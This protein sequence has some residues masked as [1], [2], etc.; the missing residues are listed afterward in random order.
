MI[1]CR[2]LLSMVAIIL[3]GNQFNNIAAND[4]VG[5]LFSDE[6]CDQLE[7]CLDDNA[8]G[9]CERV[10][11]LTAG[12]TLATYQHSLNDKTL[13]LL[14]TEMQRL[15]E[16]GNR[17]DNDYTQCV[18][19]QI[20][21][22]HRL[23]IDY[24]PG[25]C[26]RLLHLTAQSTGPK[27]IDTNRK[28]PYSTQS[29]IEY[30]PDYESDFA[31]ELFLRLDDNNK[32][33]SN[34]KTGDNRY[35]FDYK[36]MKRMDNK[37]KIDDK[38]F[39]FI[40]KL[41]KEKL[42]DNGIDDDIIGYD[43]PKH[44]IAVVDET[45]LSFDNN[46]NDN[47][48]S[49]FYDKSGN[50]IEWLPI[51]TDD[52]DVVNDDDVDDDDQ[53]IIG[54][55]DTGAH[56][57]GR[58]AAAPAVVSPELLEKSILKSVSQL[59]GG[60]IDSM[61]LLLNRPLYFKP[62]I[63]TGSRDDTPDEDNSNVDE[64]NGNNN[65][66]N[67][68]R[69]LIDGRQQQQDYGNNYNELLDN[70]LMPADG[71]NDNDDDSLVG[72]GVGDDY[73][74][75]L[76]SFY[77][78][79]RYDIK[80][81]GPGYYIHEPEAALGSDSKQQQQ[82][83]E[84]NGLDDSL[85]D[86]YSSSS[87]REMVDNNLVNNQSESGEAQSTGTI[88]KKSAAK[89]M[90]SGQSVESAVAAAVEPVIGGSDRRADNSRV[91]GGGVGGEHINRFDKL[92]LGI[93]SSDRLANS[94]DSSLLS[95]SA[96]RLTTLT[97]TLCGLI[98]VALVASVVMFLYRRNTKFRQKLQGLTSR[99]DLEASDDYQDLCRQRMHNKSNEK[100][101][102]IQVTPTGSTGVHTRGKLVSKLSQQSSGEGGNGTQASPPSR[103]STSS[104]SE[105]PVASNMDVS[106]GHLILSYM[107]DHLKKKDR[108]DREWE[109]LCAYE[110]DPCSTLAAGL[111]Q[112]AKKNRFSD[113]LPYDHSRVILNDMANNTGS[114]YINA[115]T[116]TDHDPRN[117]AYIATQG[118][119]AHTVTDFWQMVWEQGS[120][121]IVM[122]SRLME[123]G[124][125][126]CHRYWPEEGSEV[127]HNYEVHLVSEHIW[128]DDYL[129]RSFYLKNL[130]T[131]ET[132][133]VTQFH[134]L[135]W[136]ENGVPPSAKAILEFRRKVNKSYRGR[137]CP[138]VVH[139]SDG[140]GR[141]GT[142]TVIDMVLNRMTK[143]AKEIDIAATLEHI[144]DQRMAM[145]KTKAQFE[146]VLTAV[147][148]EVQ[149]ILKA[150][151]QNN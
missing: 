49:L 6:L 57:G 52:I 112:N 22:T 95:S 51:I 77:R 124:V 73:T 101:E 93:Q 86:Y 28:K 34:R 144:R 83:E 99:L 129:V 32:D 85:V 116:I 119:L 108:L 24:D 135:S 15:Y 26:S 44:K 122:L 53:D 54:V 78:Q 23:H 94:A 146:Y 68:F 45:D 47:K 143:G 131:G 76:S 105:E 11:D 66:N 92:T 69:Q 147:A 142:Y 150:L 43:L 97:L 12:Q 118:P 100:Q 18:V 98:L 70:N 31:K 126:M 55:V 20:L 137:A 106:T 29:D 90:T 14:E 46:N 132:R 103:S 9:R 7:V 5:C 56:T 127:Y 139:C 149:A 110:A 27:T 50:I 72:A 37:I 39:K 104:W 35:Q 40:K 65:N 125:A 120:V 136:P 151:A 58:A 42:I 128:S 13:R 80:K 36:T 16:S 17:W 123:N 74:D 19:K 82:I 87:S 79:H 109:A 61:S 102:S 134:F 41:I 111:P 84:T 4:N 59:N 71:Y 81:P 117:P 8:F 130:K 89:L 25:L 67:L 33:N 30:I 2:L 113:I 96:H 63:T 75:A 3:V 115:N 145:V 121:I 64:E 60:D 38:V 48:P 88:D 148:E 21:Y 114:D 62:I 91:S 141:T 133:T 107:E 138:I 140:T 1:Y 10:E